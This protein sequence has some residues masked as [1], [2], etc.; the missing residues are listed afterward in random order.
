MSHP[1]V[2][3]LAYGSCETT[4]VCV[5]NCFQAGNAM[6]VDYTS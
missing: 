5:A 2:C 1:P 3:V 4:F 6:V